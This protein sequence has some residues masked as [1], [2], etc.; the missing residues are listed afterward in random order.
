M[1]YHSVCDLHFER[2]GDSLTSPNPSRNTSKEDK[3]W[4]YSLVIER[5]LEVHEA[6]NRI[7]SAKSGV[8]GNMGSRKISTIKN[9]NTK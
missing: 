3:R 1:R 5:L 7:T 6:L 4:G 8:E 2:Q 9:I